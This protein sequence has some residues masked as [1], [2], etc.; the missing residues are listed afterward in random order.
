MRLGVAG[1][2][3]AFML[4]L[5]TLRTDPRI[6]LVAA[7]APRSE[8]REAFASEFSASTYDSVDALAADPTVEAIYIATPHQLHADHVLACLHQGKHVLVDKPLAVSMLDADRMVAAAA[9]AGVHLIVGPSHSFDAPV[10]LAR[11]LIDSG[12]YGRVRMLHALNFTDFLYRPR[13][14][15]ELQTEAGGGV[16][17]SQGIHQIDIVRLLCGGL[18]SQVYAMTGRWDPD[19]PTEGA[20]SAMIGFESGAFASLTYS[21]YAHFDSDTWMGDIGELGHVKS[22]AHY[23]Q[24]RK[25]L[26]GLSPDAEQRLKTARTYAPGAE[27][28]IPTHHEHFGPII[29]LCE[30]A[31]LRLTPDGVEVSGDHDRS[32]VKAPPLQ[33]PRESVIDTLIAAVRDDQ[34]PIQDGAWGRA[35]L[36]I[37]HA[38]LQSADSGVAVTLARQCSITK[39]EAD[40]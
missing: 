35:S 33:I 1:L 7:T 37:C 21:G 12:H 36:E 40:A 9:E 17:F 19:R 28:P 8:S 2:G 31:D 23:G 38:I 14:P 3:R 29:V 18:A 10:V 39:R 25:A 24:A 27:P 26:Q 13:R 22:P 11:Q 32:F 34:A 30:H 20:Y 6:R 15:E 4:M 16:L 5:P